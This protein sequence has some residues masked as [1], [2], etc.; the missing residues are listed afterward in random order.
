MTTAIAAKQKWNPAPEVTDHMGNPLPGDREFLAPPPPEIGRVISAWSTLRATAAA[1]PGWVKLLI[2]LF[3]AATA[4]YGTYFIATR[5]SLIHARQDE[6]QIVAAIAG[7]GVAIIVAAT[8]KW[9]HQCNYVGED[10]VAISSTGIW[11]GGRKIWKTRFL[12]FYAAAAIK[13]HQV[14]HYTNGIYTG[15]QF[16]FA[17][18]GPTGQRVFNLAG[19]HH[20][21]KGRPKPNSKFNLAL[22]AELI[23]SRHYLQRALLELDQSGF[24]AFAAKGADFVR[25]GPGVI[26]FV[27][28]GQPV[29]MQRSEIRDV[30]MAGGT[31]TFYHNDAKWFSSRGKYSLEYGQLSNARVFLL[32]LD[33]VLGYR[34]E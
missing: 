34:F 32:L 27:F 24:A 31:L 33:K 16:T 10:G 4:A 25:I 11:R 26:E 18:F 17:W 1:S 9:K 30:K 7:C 22:A 2:M 3:C 28:R 21:K 15:T 12:P 6:L 14:R 19:S 29:Q 5:G 13:T 23:W 8:F 20:N